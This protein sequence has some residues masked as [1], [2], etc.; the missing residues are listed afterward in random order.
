MMASPATPVLSESQ[1]A[2]LRRHG[3]ERSA[4]VGDVLFK[5]GDERYPFMAI[6]E[7]EAAI[8]DAAGH[9]IVRHGASGFLGEMNLMSGQTVYLT[10]VVTQPMRYIAVDRD[11]LR[12]L[13]FD[14]GPLS[15]L[16]LSTFMARR[17]ALQ[18]HE[19]VGI[20]IVG[21]RSSEATRR[22]V[23]FVRRNRLPY[24]WR[25]SERS[26]DSAAATLIEGIDHQPLPLVRLPGGRELRNPSGGEVSRGLGIG[27]ELAPREEVDLVVIGGGPAGLGAAVY[28]ASEGLDTLVVEGT[29][30]GGQ[31]GTSRRI[32]N[33]LGFPAGISGSE[34]TTR[35]VS[36]A[37][38]FNARTATPYRAIALEPGTDRHVVRL[39]DDHE[40]A[41]RAVLLATGADYRRL[42]IAGLEEYE[43]V[44]VFYA[45]GPP[46]AQRCGATRV[47]VIGG[48]NSAAQ[49]AIWLARGGALVTLMHRRADLRETMSDYLIVELER[50]GVAVRDR[51][52]V[53]ELHGEDG[54][55]EA[56]TLR[57][58][59]RLP[60]SFLFL[61]LG[62][63]PCTE[64][65][66][67]V[68]A[69]DAKGF[70]ITGADAGADGLLET[71]VPGIYAAGDVRSGSIKRCATAVGEGAMVVRFV[72]QHLSG[73]PA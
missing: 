1:L 17:E 72:H 51:S 57:D 13:L 49:A 29:A 70:V 71:S 45:A 68:L 28:G 59:E 36:Q 40:V 39:E 41:A 69:R 8:L 4:A 21:P 54:Q 7:G 18:Q 46:E 27:L 48:G 63:A 55:L 22:M 12:G 14:D 2:T 38:K 32:E 35:A 25:D 19:G 73:V 42:P 11:E 44:S 16:L 67:D 34:L 23:E 31:A 24:T 43:G 65:L 15:D 20:E 64:W 60:F 6:I 52:E 66:G 53:A 3:E 56:V 58:G 26:E 9:E 62:A 10:A 61:F 5:V 37:R 33:Y 47:G 30:L 50:Y